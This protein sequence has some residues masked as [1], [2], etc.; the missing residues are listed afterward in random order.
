MVLAALRYPYFFYIE[1]A[2]ARA[3]DSVCR[4]MLKAKFGVRSIYTLQHAVSFCGKGSIHN[5]NKN[6]GEDSAVAETLQSAGNLQSYSLVGVADG[7]GGWGRHGID[8]G[9]LSQ[10]LTKEMA[11]LFREQNTIAK[12]P[13]PTCQ[14]LLTDAFTTIYNRGSMYAG[15]TTVCMGVFDPHSSELE[16]LNLGDSGALVCRNG[17]IELSTTAEVDG[18]TPHQLTVL[19]EGMHPSQFAIDLDPEVQTKA[20]S[21]KWKLEK[22]D[23]VLFATDGFFDNVPLDEVLRILK[24]SPN[25]SSAEVGNKLLSLAYDNSLNQNFASPFALRCL[26]ETEFI[27]WGGKPDDIS[28]VCGFVEE[29]TSP[30][31]SKL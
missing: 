12:K 30:R 31:E 10:G 20:T 8:S 13:V 6:I 11:S 29:T 7:V 19:P 9:K 15:G 24:E 17:K 18:M 23:F 3:S 16:V 2:Y 5:R 27:Y 28:L 4:V 22:G 26:Q 1:I 21:E 14:Q 25:A